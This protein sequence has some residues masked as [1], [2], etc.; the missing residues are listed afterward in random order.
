[1][2]DDLAMGYVECDECGC[3]IEQ[4]DTTGCRSGNEGCTCGVTWTR[5]E[6]R[7]VRKSEGLSATY[8]KME[9]I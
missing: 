9:L 1:M 5:D 7:R 3:P 4:H 8:K 6:I 2:R